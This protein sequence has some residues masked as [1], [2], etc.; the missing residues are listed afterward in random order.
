MKRFGLK[1][2]ELEE[3]ANKIE[4]EISNKIELS[5]EQVVSLINVCYIQQNLKMKSGSLHEEKYKT[6]DL[7]YLANEIKKGK[8]PLEI[9]NKILD[10][11]EE[12]SRQQICN[13]YLK[14]K[15]S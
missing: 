14:D 13:K 12:Y 10:E 1:M 5:K 3:I 15:L 6:Y 4:L 2:N 8:P 9:M 7:I 11:C